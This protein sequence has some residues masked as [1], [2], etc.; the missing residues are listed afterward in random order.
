MPDPTG[1]VLSL[2]FAAAHPEGKTPFD[3][4]DTDD[5]GDGRV[6][7]RGVEESKDLRELKDR[8]A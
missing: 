2:A 4:L 8:R 7:V 3:L 6:D 5:K 1:G